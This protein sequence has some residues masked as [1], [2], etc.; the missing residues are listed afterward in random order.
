MEEKAKKRMV[1]KEDAHEMQGVNVSRTAPGQGARL[2]WGLRF[3][4]AGVTTCIPPMGKS[5]W[6]QSHP[7]PRAGFLRHPKESPRRG[8][9]GH[10]DTQGLQ[11]PGAGKDKNERGGG[12]PRTKGWGGDLHLK[13]AHTGGCTHAPAPT[14]EQHGDGMG[15]GPGTSSPTAP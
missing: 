4:R 1:L 9:G 7:L 10:S 6:V 12:E 11:H 2:G 5:Q 8:R 14:R 13:P 3:E 15:L